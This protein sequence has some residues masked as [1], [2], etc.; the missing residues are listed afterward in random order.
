MRKYLIA[1][2]L[3]FCFANVA[4][5]AN[6]VPQWDSAPQ[7]ECYDFLRYN[8][9]NKR[10][11]KP[12]II[13]RLKEPAIPLGAGNV[14]VVGGREQFALFRFDGLDREWAF[15]EMGKYIIILRP[16][17]IASYYDFRGVGPGEKTKPKQ[18][19]ICEQQ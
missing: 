12:P 13:L 4:H 10:R 18:H 1:A 19:F 17:K 11:G 7:W 16:N 8:L 3:I 5:P 2:V 9:A 6:K 15:G 14:E